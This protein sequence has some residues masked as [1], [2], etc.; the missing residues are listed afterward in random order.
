MKAVR[1]KACGKCILFGEHFVVS[2]S[3][4]LALPL[5]DLACEVTV[6]P[7][8][9]P[10]YS[11]KFPGNE[12]FEIV[13]SVMARAFYAAADSLR[14]DISAQPMRVESVATF[15][16]SRGFGSSAAFAVALA[17]ALGK[18]RDT[19]ATEKAELSE[20]IKGAAAVERIFHGQPS[21]VDAAVIFAEHPIRFEKGVIVRNVVNRAVDILVLDGG[22]RE[23]CSALVGK[24]AEFRQTHP[25]QWA[26]MAS[27]NG[28]LVD[29]SEKAL[30]DGDTEAVAVAVQRAHA[31]LADLRLSTPSI[32]GLIRKAVELGAL[33]GKV[34]GA[35]AG[36]A[37]LLVAKKGDGQALAERLKGA[38]YA[39][40][41]RVRAEDEGAI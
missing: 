32:D 26:Q 7:D 5:L 21:G 39:T 6:A 34:S 40:M 22:S 28:N 3:P 17:R 16:V 8:N 38:G 31:M 37:V 11:A 18:Y 19:I 25:Q 10:H 13:E 4:A 24:V 1:G 33:A 27:M 41:A 36:G 23:N 30:K 2:G 9:H 35:G 20:L 15:P 12:D 14:L 29:C